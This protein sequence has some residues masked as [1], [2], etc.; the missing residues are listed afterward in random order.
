MTFAE[1]SVTAPHHG[2]GCEARPKRAAR[3]PA[4]SSAIHQRRVQEPRRKPRAAR[5]G[6]KRPPSPNGPSHDPTLP[7]R[8]D[9]ETDRDPAPPAGGL[10]TSATEG[11]APETG[12]TAWNRQGR[13]AGQP[14]GWAA[15]A[16]LRKPQPTQQRRR[17]VDKG[18]SQRRA[19]MRS[20]KRNGCAHNEQEAMEGADM[21][22]QAAQPP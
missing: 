2:P 18:Q 1:T 13:V 9:R 8:S 12:R 14:R 15:P 20:N 6:R 21:H 4:E 3:R 19:Q 17:N 16:Q 7:G 11:A 22:R 10:R 5:R